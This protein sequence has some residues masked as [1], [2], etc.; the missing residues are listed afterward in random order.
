MTTNKPDQAFILAAGKGTRLRPYT[1]N[2]P[3]PMV[4][5][6]GKPIL[7]YILEK[8]NAEDVQHC[9]INL[10]YLGDRIENFF[11]NWKQPEI[12]FSKETDL[13]ETGG[14]VKLGLQYLNNT[15]FYLI[16]GDALWEDK[17]NSKTALRQL[18][19]AWNPAKMD[20]L[21]LLQPTS[22][23]TLT[24]GVGDYNLDT[25]GQAIRTPD[26]SGNHMFTGIRIVNPA[27]FKETPDGA[28][29]FLQCMDKAQTQGRLHGI[30]YDGLWHHI[31]T[32]EDLEAVNQAFKQDV[33]PNSPAS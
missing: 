15:P 5:V 19:D 2:M 21:L 9:V 33:Q 24:K 7:K 16:N 17:T 3:K 26:K 10:F 14:G 13:L 18:S 32:P 29:S 6:N 27:I 20:I 31:S 4:E 23:M 25:S 12:T 30:S 11:K 28:F 1:D 8:L 22:T